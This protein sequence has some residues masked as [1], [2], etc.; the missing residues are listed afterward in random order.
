[1]GRLRRNLADFAVTG[2]GLSSYLL[3]VF[4]VW[5]PRRCF[6]TTYKGMHSQGGRLFDLLLSVGVISVS[7]SIR[8]ARAKRGIVGGF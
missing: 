6:V 4:L 3:P 2:L 1:M 7:S 5:L 8:K